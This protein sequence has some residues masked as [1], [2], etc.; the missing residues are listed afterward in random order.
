MSLIASSLSISAQDSGD[1]IFNND[2]LH[3]VYIDFEDDNFWNVLK[4]N[5]DSNQDSP[6]PYIMASVTIDGETVDSVGIRLKGFTSYFTQT[7]KKPIKIDFN[8]YVPGQ[9]YDGLRKLNLNNGTADPSLQRDP[10]CYRLL[11]KLGVDAPRTSYSR[12]YLNDTFWGLYQNIEQVDKEFL[13]NNYKDNDGHLIKNKG[14]SHLEWN[15]PNHNDYHPPFELKTNE[16][17]PD[18]SG[19]VNFVDILN[20]ADEDDFITEISAIFD[21][22]RF[23]KTL[24][25]DIATNNWDSYMEHGR[26]YYIYQDTSDGKFKWIPWDYNLAL[27]GVLDFGSDCD[28]FPDFTPLRDGTTTVEFLDNSFGAKTMATYEWDLGDG[29]TTIETNFTH[30]YATPGTYEVCL[31]I[32][33]SSTCVETICQMVDTNF[34]PSDCPTFEDNDITNNRAFQQTLNWNSDCCEEWGL[35]CQDVYDW[36]V[37]NE[38]GEG[39]SFSFEIDQSENS[40]VLINRLLNDESTKDRYYA[41]FCNLM[42]NVMLEEDLLAYMDKNRALIDQSVQED[43]NYLYSYDEFK[44]DHNLIENDNSLVNYLSNRI[45]NLKEEL[46]DLGACQGQGNAGY[47]DIVINEFAASNDSLGAIKDPDGDSDDWIELFNTTDETIDISNLYLTDNLNKLTKWQFPSGS[48]MKPYEYI[49]VWTDKDESTNGYHADFKLSK[50]GE[51]IGLSNVNGSIIDSV[52]FGEQVTNQAAARI[53]NGSGNFVIQKTTHGYNNEWSSSTK[54]NEELVVKIYPNPATS[55]INV[56]L[57]DDAN[58]TQLSIYNSLGSLVKSALLYESNNAINIQDL[59]AGIYLVQLKSEEG[60][61]FSHK[62]IV[63]Q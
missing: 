14:W 44:A 22:D 60:L 25:V 23:L 41:H 12:V 40:G 61:L 35:G 54:E 27:G 50:S 52:S 56:S 63:Q 43:P 13:K 39:G 6:I 57:E 33:N 62:I 32:T 45:A 46:D 2:I 10:V 58:G 34:D 30:I 7:D 49:I 3:E 8:E 24:A 21:V 11:N 53:P 20:N 19:F 36:I 1:K 55:I 18:W 26:N 9:R 38:S 47:K 28:L 42:N 59:T 29:N 5:Y 4:S 37:E 31:S 16:E 48:T 17:S 15:G 51:S